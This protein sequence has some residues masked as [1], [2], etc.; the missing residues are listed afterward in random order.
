MHLGLVYIANE[1][2][3]IKIN[4]ITDCRKRP[5]DASSEF[6]SAMNNVFEIMMNISKDFL[7]KSSMNSG[8][9]VDSEIEFAELICECMVS[10]G[11]TNLQCI[12]SDT[13]KLSSYLQQV[14]FLY[15]VLLMP[16]KGDEDSSQLC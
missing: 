5:A 3:F 12:S 16:L 11:S 4:N 1:L 8:A 13:N 7:H 15:I 10:L 14:T 2:S 6:D 9:T